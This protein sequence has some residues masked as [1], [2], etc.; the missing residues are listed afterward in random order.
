MWWVKPE[1][2]ASLWTIGTSSLTYGAMAWRMVEKRIGGI[3]ILGYSLAGEETVLA[4][5][6]LNIC[7][8]PGRAPPD[9]IPIDNL[10]VSHG[11]MDHAAGVAYYLSQRGFVGNAPGRIIIHRNL[12]QHVQRLM[13]VWADLEGHHSPG[14]IEGVVGGDEIA[15]RR[16]LVLRTFDVVHSYG[17]LGFAIV[18]KRHKLKAEYIGYTGPQ[19]VELKRKGVDIHD[20]VEKPLIA[21]CGDTAVGDFF[22]LDHVR[23]A[24]VILLECT[25]FIDEHVS[26]ARAGRHIHVRDLADI[27]PR[28]NC[29]HVVL[30]HLT[31]R[32]G[33][34]EAKAILEASIPKAERRRVSILMDRPH[35]GPRPPRGQ[36]DCEPSRPPVQ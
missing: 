16:D 6:E 18:E 22:N 35:R 4:V 26:R 27:L 15:L 34:R 10:C 2:P 29:S 20:H 7:F 19:L 21:Y 12:A 30:T 1:K 17:S 14:L 31:R 11:H 3:R 9:I 5:P 33:M 36:R 24:E 32:T 28:L 8:D 13:S 23:N 25:F